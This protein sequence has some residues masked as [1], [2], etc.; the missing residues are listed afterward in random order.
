MAFADR[1]LSLDR[2]VPVVP[3]WLV[4]PPLDFEPAAPAPELCVVAV[5]EPPPGALDPAWP[6]ALADPPDEDEAPPTLLP[7]AAVEL[8]LDV[9]PDPELEQLASSDKAN[10]PINPLEIRVP[11]RFFL[12]MD[13]GVLSLGFRV[14]SPFRAA[15]TDFH[16]FSHSSRMNSGLPGNM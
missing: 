14:G 6:P 7:P 11:G 1:L 13:S 9:P 2:V 12:M 16:D 3:P 15:W 10:V 5:L 4:V 8:E